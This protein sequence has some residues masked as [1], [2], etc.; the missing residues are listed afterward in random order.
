MGAPGWV[1]TAGTRSSTSMWR[2]IL[3]IH[4][5][6]GPG[7]NYPPQHLPTAVQTHLEP[8]TYDFPHSRGCTVPCF[9]TLRDR[10]SRMSA[11]GRFTARPEA[12]Y[13][14]ALAPL[15][16][17]RLCAK[18][19]GTAPRQL[20]LRCLK[21]L[22]LVLYLLHPCSRALPCARDIPFIPQGTLSTRTWSHLVLNIIA[23][24]CEVL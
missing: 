7:S 9:R 19:K 18:L 24:S 23:Q 1:V 6:Y 13:C 10:K 2:S 20:L 11:H 16:V 22:L 5:S 4:V 14:A 15:L 21:R 12:R 17:S 8:L 3:D